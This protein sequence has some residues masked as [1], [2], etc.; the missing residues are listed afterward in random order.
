MTCELCSSRVHARGW[1]N[2]HY[3]RWV[4]WGDPHTVN[5]YGRHRE[6]DRCL[7]CDRMAYVRNLC[8]AHYYR[9]QRYGDPTATP[10]TYRRQAFSRKRI[11]IGGTT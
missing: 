6:Q 9:W 2:T 4:R 11:P 8:S 7:H 3:Q 1:C 5:E 10:V